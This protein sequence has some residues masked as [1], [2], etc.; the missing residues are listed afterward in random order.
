LVF[1]VA[2]HQEKAADGERKDNK[3][4]LPQ[5]VIRY[6]AIQ[7]AAL[8][9]FGTERVALTQRFVEHVAKLFLFAPLR[10]LQ[11]VKDNRS[12]HDQRDKA[13][14]HKPD[15]CVTV[16]CH[17]HNVRQVMYVKNDRQG[18]KLYSRFTLRNQQVLSECGLT[19]FMSHSS[20]DPTEMDPLVMRT[21]QLLGESAR[22]PDIVSTTNIPASLFNSDDDEDGP[23]PF[24]SDQDETPRRFTGTSST[25]KSFSMGFDAD[26]VR[27]LS[28]GDVSVAK[29]VTS[30][31]HGLWRQNAT[32]DVRDTDEVLFTIAYD[33]DGGASVVPL[34]RSDSELH[35]A[36]GEDAFEQTVPEFP[37]EGL[38]L[39]SLKNKCSNPMCRCV[40]LDDET[41]YNEW[42]LCVACDLLPKTWSCRDC[43][44]SNTIV[45]A[46]CVSCNKSR[47]SLY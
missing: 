19:F 22:N 21:I 34:V 23:D 26:C 29:A 28:T 35:Q 15:G 3:K 38:S 31:C 32:S 12:A 17:N 7:L 42:G 46:E 33:A 36:F 4:A 8:G 43:N 24:G 45:L 5:H 41:E 2:L 10:R 44:W 39:L 6:T 30:N 27:S 25:S 13:K 20:R 18:S 1:L 16:G 11:H 40:L 14:Q 47:F 9:T 37:T